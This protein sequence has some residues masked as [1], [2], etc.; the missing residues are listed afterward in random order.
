MDPPDDCVREQMSFLSLRTRRETFAGRWQ[1]WAS[2]VEV[3]GGQVD[4]PKAGYDDGD[5]QVDL[6][7]GD[8][9]HEG[10]AV[11]ATVYP[12]CRLDRRPW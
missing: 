1:M 11:P 12:S 3:V 9:L 2:P 7:C 8:A 10:D 4:L 6:M 5:A